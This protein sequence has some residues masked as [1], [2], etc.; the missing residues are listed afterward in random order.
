MKTLF[1]LILS[2]ILSVLSAHGQIVTNVFR[3][4]NIVISPP[5]HLKFT[6]HI[7]GS[8]IVAWVGGRADFVPPTNSWYFSSTNPV[9]INHWYNQ[10]VI[11][12]VSSA[13]GWQDSGMGTMNFYN[14]LYATNDKWSGAIRIQIYFPTNLLWTGTDSIPIN[15]VGASTN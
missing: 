1:I 11:L 15:V 3:A 14:P 9:W 12:W 2:S 7:G 8:N 5:Q 10:G 6:N 13:Y 4:T